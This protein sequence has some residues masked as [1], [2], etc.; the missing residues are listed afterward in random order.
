MV[1]DNS[2]SLDKAKISP[3]EEEAGYTQI[4]KD[5]QSLEKA[6][7][8]EKAKA[9]DYLEGWKRAQADFINFKRRTEQERTEATKYANAALILNVLPVLDD[10]Q[11][12]FASASGSAASLTWVNGMQLILRKLEGILESQGLSQLKALGEKFDPRFHEAVMYKDGEEEVV[13]EEV[14]K[15]YKL[16]DK[17]IRPALVVVG[18]GQE[19]STAEDDSKKSSSPGE[20]IH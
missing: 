7:V 16:H 18:K 2:P 17:V 6:L 8:D 13:I 3:P 19:K 11:R 4:S 12:A 5:V 15:G 9:D 14:Q 1:D 10:L 20:D